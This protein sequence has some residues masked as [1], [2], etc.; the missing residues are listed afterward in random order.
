M[1]P[2]D[3]LNEAKDIGMGMGLPFNIQKFLEKIILSCKKQEKINIKDTIVS[4]QRE[5]KSD[6]RDS[7]L[8]ESRQ[9]SFA[10]Y[11]N[12]TRQFP[13]DIVYNPIND[14]SREKNIN[15]EKSNKTDIPLIGLFNNNAG[16]RGFGPTENYSGFF[17]E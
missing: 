10:P 7:F 2:E 16:Q 3:A 9:G 1:N 6:N 12:Y 14:Q 4:N 17:Y 13:Y 5:Y 11:L 15:N 8:D